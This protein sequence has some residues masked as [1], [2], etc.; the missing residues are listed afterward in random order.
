MQ[1]VSS[2]RYV[3]YVGYSYSMNPLASRRIGAYL[4]DA[5]SYLGIAAATIPFGLLAVRTELGKSQGFVL[6]ASAV[7][8][9]I[10]LGYATHAEAR[11]GTWGKRRFN[12]R[13]NRVGGGPVS[14]G[15]ALVRNLVKFAIP[16]QLG[17]T[18]AISAAFGRF[19]RPDPTLFGITIVT[20]AVIGA[21]IWGILRSSG[22]TLH[23][24]I[25]STRVVDATTKTRSPTD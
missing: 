24:M 16:W 15:S 12:L 7:P 2:L 13:V 22:V 1:G 9:A 21:G 5:T 14:K 25:A 10:A 11:G 19:H 6:T 8:V 3:G 20:Y 18:V 23:D 4:L 17:H